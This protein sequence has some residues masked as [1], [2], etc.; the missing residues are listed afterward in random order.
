VAQLYPGHCVR[1]NLFPCL[2]PQEQGGPIIP[3]ALRKTKLVSLLIS[4]RNRVAQLYPGHCVRQSL[5]PCLYPPGTGW[6][7]YTPGTAKDKACFLASFRD[8]LGGAGWNSGIDVRKR[9]GRGSLAPKLLT[10][11]REYNIKYNCC[12][13]CC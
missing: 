11:V 12:V 5:F 4:P 10:H 13:N 6:P 9:G 7:S 3:R 1:Q 2:Y 8:C